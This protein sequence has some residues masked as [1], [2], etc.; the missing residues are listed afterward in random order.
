[1][2]NIHS[3]AKK[4]RKNIKGISEDVL[5]RWSPRSM[6]AQKLPESILYPL[7]E[8]ASFAPSAFNNQPWRFYYT[9]RESKSFTD[10]LNLLAQFNQDWCRNA[11][12]LIILVSKK[13]YDYNGKF[14]RTHAFDVGAA[15]EAFAIEGVRR[16]LVVHG[17]SGFDYEKAKEYLKL[18]DDY[19]IECMIAVGQPTEKVRS[20]EVS[21]RK[22]IKEIAIKI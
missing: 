2:I 14:D 5:Y 17:M 13:T 22:A 8:A 16:N 9:H 6:N 19:S 18:N 20:E 11:S 7:F 12:F 15:W 3:C 1:M 21:T 4:A 10:L